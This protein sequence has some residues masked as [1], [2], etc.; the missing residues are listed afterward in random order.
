MI[1]S[2]KVSPPVPMILTQA[3]EPYEQA[4]SLG[5]RQNGDTAMSARPGTS[6]EPLPASPADRGMSPALP[7]R[8]PAQQ[9]RRQVARL[10]LQRAW[11]Q[12][13]PRP[14]PPCCGKPGRRS[15]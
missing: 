4:A 15:R 7:L 8:G 9:V 5:I 12:L 10:R 3:L 14:G 1:S 2:P 6:P 11:Q 13:R